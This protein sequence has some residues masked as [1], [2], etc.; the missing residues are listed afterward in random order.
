MIENGVDLYYEEHGQG[1]PVIFVHGFP[2][3][4][5]TWSPLVPLLGKHN[6]RL[7]LP[8]LRGFGQSLV[9]KDPV[10]TMRLFAEDILA[11]MDRLEIEKAVLVGHSMG[12]YVSLNFAHAFPGRLA[13]LGL[14]GTQAGADKP[15]KRQGRMK[16]A[17]EIKRRGIERATASLPEKFSPNPDL[18]PVVREYFLKSNPST[19][20][21]SLKGMAE[22]PDMTEQLSNIRV[23]AL[24]MLGDKDQ[25]VSP[26]ATRTMNQL[27]PWSWLVELPGC[28]HMLS[29][30]APE[31]VAD[32]I[33]KLLHTV[34]SNLKA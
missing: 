1:L 22:R 30:E 26:E 8:D 23:P 34:Q 4:H 9:A 10:Y 14:I 13:G 6:A 33:H 18:V 31:Q 17:D 21:A 24:V 7:I 2:F 28:G 20:I 5:T 3:D 19:L 32:A 15:E 25:M 29:L 12:G 11:L 27:L 16:L